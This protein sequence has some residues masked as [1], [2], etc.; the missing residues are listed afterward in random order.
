[1][2]KT[3]LLGYLIAVVGLA[4]LFLNSA[5]ARKAIPIFNSVPSNI[6]LTI[7]IVVILAGVVLTFFSTEKVSQES[8]EVPIYKGKKIVGYRKAE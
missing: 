6:L 1:M 2:A 8:E 4:I 5:P 3:K 7:G